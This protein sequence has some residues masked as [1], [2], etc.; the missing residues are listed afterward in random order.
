MLVRNTHAGTGG[1][2]SY[3]LSLSVILSYSSAT[4]ETDKTAWNIPKHLA[5][6]TFKELPGKAVSITVTPL[7]ENTTTPFFAAT[8]KPIPYVPSFPASTGIA[9]YIGL[10]LDLVQPPLPEG[11]GAEGE[12]PGTDR[13]C[14]ITP[15]QSSRKVSLGWWDMKQGASEEDALLNSEGNS[16]GTKPVENENWWPGSGRWKIGMIMEDAEVRFPEGKYWKGPNL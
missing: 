6:F 1:P 8:F 14:K 11:K 4:R 7:D 3:D 9:K 2:V 13:W 16:S 10:D 12:L 5:R 15:Y